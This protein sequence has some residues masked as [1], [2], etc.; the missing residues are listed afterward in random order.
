[1]LELG[2]IGVSLTFA[3]A[4]LVHY[5][6]M[7][8]ALVLFQALVFVSYILWLLARPK[9]DAPAILGLRSE[10]AG[11]REQVDTLKSKVESM[12]LGGRRQ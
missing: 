10:I 1:M 11:L 8:G 9:A 2:L 12:I 6:P 7:S 5:P 3:L 4:A